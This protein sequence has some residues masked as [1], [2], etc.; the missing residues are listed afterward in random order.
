MLVAFCDQV[1]GNSS[2][3]CSKA[4][5]PSRQ[6]VITA[7]PVPGQLVVRVGSPAGEVAAHLQAL[8]GRALLDRQGVPG[9][10]HDDLLASPRGGWHL[11]T[12]RRGGAQAADRLRGPGGTATDRTTAL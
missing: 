11:F 4:V 5:V 12:S 1:L 2:P 9:L 3:R 8:A 6:L 10:G 7:S